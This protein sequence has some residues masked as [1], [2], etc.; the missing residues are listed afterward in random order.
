MDLQNSFT[1]VDV[2]WIENNTAVKAAWAKQRW[3]KDV[4]TVR[5]RNHDRA[6]V[7]FEAIHLNQNLVQGL[8]T[9][10]V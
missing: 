8:F 5:S 9:F 7:W 6:E 10:I 3:I 4:W 1:I 2:W